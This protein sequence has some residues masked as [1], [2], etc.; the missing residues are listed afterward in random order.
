MHGAGPGHHQED[1]ESARRATTAAGNLGHFHGPARISDEPGQG[2]TLAQVAHSVTHMQ[3]IAIPRFLGSTSL[4]VRDSTTTKVHICTMSCPTPRPPV[5]ARRTVFGNSTDQ[6]ARR[7][8]ASLVQHCALAELRLTICSQGS[9]P[10]APGLDPT[11]A[12]DPARGRVR[13]RLS[14]SSWTSF[15]RHDGLYPLNSVAD[16]TTA[17]TLEAP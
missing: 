9:P 11:L 3:S 7:A 1:P 8:V 17:H 4:R 14:Q 10:S 5:G 16:A 12:S 2:H 13:A 6:H 15:H